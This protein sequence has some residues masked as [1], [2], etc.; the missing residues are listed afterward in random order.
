LFR[1]NVI[2]DPHLIKD[3]TKEMEAASKNMEKNLTGMQ[4]KSAL[5]EYYAATSKVKEKAVW[6]KSQSI[7]K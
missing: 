1:E 7:F 4:K 2:L 3:G 6:Y 5:L